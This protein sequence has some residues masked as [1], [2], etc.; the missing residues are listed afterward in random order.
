MSGRVRGSQK[1]K[2]TSNFSNAKDS[3]GGR[4]NLIPKNNQGIMIGKK[5]RRRSMRKG[6]IMRQEDSGP[7]RDTFRMRR[8]ELDSSRDALQNDL[9]ER[10]DRKNNDRR[11][12]KDFYRYDEENRQDGNGDRLH[13]YRPSNSSDEKWERRRNEEKHDERKNRPS[14]SHTSSR[15]HDRREDIDELDDKNLKEKSKRR[16]SG[17]YRNAY[18]HNETSSRRHHHHHR[19]RVGD[20]HRSLHGISSSFES[21][22]HRREREEESDSS[23]GHHRHHHRRRHG[24]S[25][26]RDRTP[27]QERSSSHRIDGSSSHAG[28]RHRREDQKQ[29]G[30][31]SQGKGAESGG[32]RSGMV[33]RRAPPP[34]PR[35]IFCHICG[36]RH[37]TVQCERL[38]SHPDQYPLMTPRGCWKC[39]RMGHTSYLCSTPAFRCKDCGGVHPTTTCAFD[40]PS[41]E[42]HEFYC[43]TKDR[44]F[45][46]NSDETFKT[47]EAPLL[48]PQ[49]TLL[50]YCPKCCLMIPHKYEECLNCHLSRP[51]PPP[52]AQNSS[53]IDI[54]DGNAKETMENKRESDSSDDLLS[55]ISSSSRSDALSSRDSSS[56]SSSLSSCQ[57]SSDDDAL[58]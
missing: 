30:T 31:F 28:R 44:P 9:H 16:S 38:L 43:A 34:A 22:S 37:W 41:V 10:R 5:R 58:P 26:D 27:S 20:A 54:G 53:F 18:D 50:W 48:N 42:W 57:D 47:W 8:E 32:D 23:S 52:S 13:R 6:K 21:R 2:T 56:I 29:N 51:H 40:I 49:D 14:H 35:Y 7:F 33:A 25:K 55:S 36:Q 1:K 15:R 17:R 4:N 19:D 12:E 11:R 3:N 39:A 24:R 45:Y 46:S